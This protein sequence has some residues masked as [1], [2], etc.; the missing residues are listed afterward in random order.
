[1]RKIRISVFLPLLALLFAS[2]GD[3]SL[4]VPELE[5]EP[6]T[7]I[8]TLE[9]GSL[10][11]P[12]DSIP[13]AVDRQEGTTVDRLEVVLENS[14]GEVLGTQTLNQ[15]QI[16]SAEQESIAV[17]DLQPGTYRLVFT[18]YDGEVEV[19]T[20]R[21]TFF[22]S[23]DRL[24]IASVSTYPASFFPESTGLARANIEASEEADP[25]L[26]WSVQGNVI[27]EGYLSDG[28]DEVEVSAPA[29][30]GVYE[31]RMELFPAGPTENV[32]LEFS[33]T[34]AQ[35]TELVVRRNVEPGPNDLTP[36]DSY[37]ALFHFMGNTRDVGVR[38]SLMQDAPDAV[39]TIGSPQPDIREEVF[40]YYLDGSSG[41][42]V[43]DLLIP[44]RDGRPTPFS[45]NLRVV[46][47]ESFAEQSVLSAEAEDG[48]FAL[49]LVALP[50][51]DLRLEMRY[52][53]QSARFNS[54]ESLLES[55]I[56]TNISIS[57]VPGS[58]GLTVVWYRD[59]IF[60]GAES[61]DFGGALGD[62]GS[63][64]STSGGSGSSGSSGGAGGSSGSGSG[65]SS[66][67]GTTGSA[68]ESGS[69]SGGGTASNGTVSGAAASGTESVD[70]AG[71]GSESGAGGSGEVRWTRREGQTV[72]GGADGFVG[73]IDELG[74]YFRDASAQPS[75]D[76]SLFRSANRDEYGNNLVYAEGFEGT[77]IPSALEV[78]GDVSIGRSALVLSSGARVTLPSLLFSNEGIVFELDREPPDGSLS[79]SVFRHGADQPLFRVED[80][81]AVAPPEGDPIALSES[82]ENPLALRLVHDGETLTVVGTAGTAE[83]PLQGGRF[84]GVQVQA[85]SGSV[86][87]RINS[88]LAYREG[89]RFR[90]AFGTENDETEGGS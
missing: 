82:G 54:Q 50:G 34:I 61:R 57:V 52:G 28:L 72:I 10:I 80:G 41:F 56:A 23:G 59:G 67:G 63:G 18:L 3:S 13:V 73:L 7:R 64:S 36:E 83:F 2:C 6:E 37:Y 86:T 90:A 8:Q 48:S 43:N 26:R 87:V 5:Q 66:G 40:G 60:V 51:G 46:P 69:G 11:E 35:T 39:S 49:S 4:F 88:V 89:D 75:T 12:G 25:Y 15:E 22:I 78:D 16:E 14:S 55:D 47:G 29:E 33:S 19:R 65:G 70:G 32:S 76:A 81:S 84:E 31:L 38:S 27:R 24:R 21:R 9:N 74:I 45:I 53:S 42:N 79:L 17:P 77:I 68:G 30:E 44:F 85:E 1:M 20:E 62:S 58:S 71:S